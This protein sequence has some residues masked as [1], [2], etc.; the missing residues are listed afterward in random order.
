M[1]K[2]YKS[3]TI[4]D[5]ARESGVSPTTVSRVLNHKHQVSASSY[6]KVKDAMLRLRYDAPK[7]SRSADSEKRIVLLNLPTLGNPVF[8]EFV[9]GVTT[10]AKRHGWYV[11]I[12][13]DEITKATQEDIAQ[14][15]ESSR[16]VGLISMN[17]ADPDALKYLNARVPIVQSMEINPDINIPYVGVNDYAA[18]FAAVEYLIATGRRNI[19]VVLTATMRNT[20]DRYR[21]YKDALAKH[22]LQE[23][24]SLCVQAI[25]MRTNMIRTMF[26]QTI[27]NFQS[28][29]DA[30]FCVSDQSAHAVLIA[31]LEFGYRV[32]QDIAIM[33]Y[34]NSDVAELTIP[35]LSTV[36]YSKYQVGYLSCEMLYDQSQN[37][38]GIVRNTILDAE[39]VIRQST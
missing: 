23:D 33:G 37:P 17:H 7:P 39:L 24:P 14:L 22:G 10:S 3:T 2:P 9:E 5:I 35:K 8:T 13:A 34:D 4:H 26:R 11:I 20:V 6:E 19:G 29:P 28:I 31:L 16:S 15:I 12:T 27:N 25:S 1:N 30:F 38:L 21:G 36:S 18:A 32:P